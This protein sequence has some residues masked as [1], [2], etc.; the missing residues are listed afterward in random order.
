MARAIAVIM[1]LL[2]LTLLF[3]SLV[4]LVHRS[5]RPW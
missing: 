5:R 1:I 3:G 4:E 2:A